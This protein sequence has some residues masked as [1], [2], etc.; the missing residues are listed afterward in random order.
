MA[1]IVPRTGRNGNRTWQAQVRKKGYPRQTKTFDRKNDAVKWARMIERQ[2]DE[3]TWRNIQGADS[4]LMKDALRKYLDEVS[5]QKRPRTAE[6]DALSASYLKQEFGSLTMAQVTSKKVS[7]Y[8]D[9]R[10]KKTSPHSV[11]LELSLLS[12]LFNVALKEW[13]IGKFDN[14]L[15]FVKRPQVPEG[16][17]PILSEPQ[18]QKLIEE[19]KKS[20]SRFL[21]PFVLLALH[22]GCRSMELRTLRWSQVDLTEGCISLIGMMTKNHRSRIIPLTPAAVS[23]LKELNEKKGVSD[24]VFPSRGDLKKPRDMHMAFDRAVKRAGLTDIPGAGKLRIH[25]LRHLC[26]SYLL[27]SG[28]DVETVR[29][30]L[31]HRDISTT[32]KYLHVVNEHKKQAISKIGHLGLR[33]PEN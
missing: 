28:N 32:Q 26:A 23:I 9:K 13:G 11:R 17:C 24:L 8:R 2:M 6:R 22:T 19:C 14:P 5:T 3:R 27:M 12:H 16:R 4:I 10:L 25:D 33:D 18:I 15:R 30:I 1:T 20:K 29:E 21:Y 7:K 31:G